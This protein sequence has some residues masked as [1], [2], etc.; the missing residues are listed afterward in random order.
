MA[1]YREISDRDSGVWESYEP[2]RE[3][4]T[5]SKQSNKFSYVKKRQSKP[6]VVFQ[7]VVIILA[8]AGFI[9]KFI[10]FSQS[11]LNSPDEAVNFAITPLAMYVLVAV[12]F[13]LLFIWTV[14]RGDYKEIEL[15]KY[16]LFEREVLAEESE[17][18]YNSELA[19]LIGRSDPAVN[20]D[21][22]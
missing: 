4:P 16:R 9:Y 12:G 13:F 6:L 19:Q 18:T 22:N 8:G 5:L 20:L 15:P 3:R 7:W 14:L 1:L 11:V 10:E 21:H 2:R 17:G